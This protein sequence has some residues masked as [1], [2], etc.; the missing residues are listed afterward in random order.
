M[1][2]SELLNN[3]NVRTVKHLPS[4]LIAPAGRDALIQIKCSP[5]FDYN[6]LATAGLILH[7][8]H[9][10]KS[11]TRRAGLVALRQT[12]VRRCHSAT[13]P[14]VPNISEPPGSKL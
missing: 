14:R 4:P 3:G 13:E 1:A 7:S 8:R 6:G 9:L 10:L 11:K 2:M 12:F 5:I